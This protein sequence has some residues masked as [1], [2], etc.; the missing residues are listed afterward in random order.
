MAA[1]MDREKLKMSIKWSMIAFFSLAA[2][3]PLPVLSWLY[4]LA[5]KDLRKIETVAH[6]IAW[7]LRRHSHNFY[8][9]DF[10]IL[11]V[12]TMM[13]PAQKLI[14]ITERFKH[15]LHLSITIYCVEVLV[16]ILIYIPLLTI[17]LRTLYQQSMSQAKMDAIAG[18]TDGFKQSR[19]SKRIYRQRQRLVYH[20]LCVFISTA[21]FLPPAAWKFF[22][23]KGDFLHDVTWNEVTFQGLSVPLSFTGNII[24]LILNVHSYQILD[25]R[26]AKAQLAKFGASSQGGSIP[27]KRSAIKTLFLSTMDEEDI[28]LQTV[29]EELERG[30][31][32][33]YNP[34]NGTADYRSNTSG[35]TKIEQCT[36]STNI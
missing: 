3:G 7:Q 24:L 22:N 15:S 16:M 19:V 10:S 20:A 12:L 31:T 13:A 5:Y 8:R 4:V 33:K 23:S 2:V 29:S 14:P 21:V 11:N 6:G 28:L 35:E 30:A 17:S 34:A 36:F 1:N 25:E 26:K 18:S 9:A 32:T 27:R